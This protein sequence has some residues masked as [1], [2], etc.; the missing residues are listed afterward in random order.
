LSVKIL[1]EGSP[2]NTYLLL[3]NEAVA[4]GVIESGVSVVS[5]YPGTPSSEIADSIS[6]I[7]KEAGIYMEY[8]TNEIVAVEVAAGASI[9]GLRS[10]TC[11]KH[12]GVNVAADAIMTLAYTGVRAGMVIVS[13]DDPNCY[14]SQN[15]Q[16]N[17]YY[18]MLANLPMLEPSNPQEAKD[19]TIE[20]IKLS[21]KLEIP[22]FLRLTT[23]VSHTRGPVRFS[24]LMEKKLV[25]EFVKEPERFVMIPSY[26]RERHKTLLKKMKIALEISEKTK[27]NRII[28]NGSEIGIISSGVAY[29]YAV[30]ACKTVNVDASILK[31]G[32]IHPIPEKLIG[33]FIKRFDTILVVEEL[34]PYLEMAVKRIAKEYAPET[35]IYG[36]MSAELLPRYGE[37]STNLVI[38]ALLKILRKQYSNSAFSKKKDVKTKIP[39]R[40]P[41]L[42]PGCP[43]RASFYIINKVT[44]RKIICTTD[45]G[46]YALGIQSP[47]NVGDML[48]CMGA[49]VGLACGAS[50]ALNERIIAIVGDSTFFH[51]AIPGLIN[52]A[53]NGHKVTLVVLDNLTTAM[54]G[55]QPHPGMGVT[56]MKALG[57]RVMIED[58]ARACGAEF[59]AVV[60]PFKV[61]EASK[62]LK[63]AL[64]VE[65][66]SVVIFRR[67]CSLLEVREARRKGIK[68][69][70]YRI[71]ESKCT[72]CMVCIKSFGCPAIQTADG[73]V[74]INDAL[75]VGCGVCSQIC[76][77]GAIVPSGE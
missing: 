9:C 57:K 34:E 35:R 48:I 8:S 69:K 6:L 46:C 15:E 49:S 18:A 59:V 65:G 22:C 39:A 40:P 16:D 19:Y 44:G 42:C 13:A 12:V 41:V 75:C 53:Y 27:L 38:N 47:L 1:V 11:M 29:N 62:I 20:A 73:K 32:M 26:A 7:A 45:I 33:S 76:P 17:R 50:R 30:E 4:R 2:G 54:T 36:K 25:K 58:V 31:L 24:S 21:E 55:H 77:Y 67:I 72:N 56:G 23:R 64:S 52:A 71:D 60:D 51:A 63:K 10:L 28:L 68:I 74:F 43:H 5:A 37:L 61:K 14:S 3:G 66:V 70:P